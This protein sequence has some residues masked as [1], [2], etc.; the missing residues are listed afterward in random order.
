M[1]V[2]FSGVPRDSHN[3]C[4]FRIY[5]GKLTRC[6]DCGHAV[7][8]YDFDTYMD[9]AD[10]FVD[11]ANRFTPGIEVEDT[12]SDTATPIFDEWNREDILVLAEEGP[13]ADWEELRAI[14]RTGLENMA[15]T[16]NINEED[17]NELE[18]A[19]ENLFLN[20]SGDKIIFGRSNKKIIEYEKEM[21]L[22]QQ[23]K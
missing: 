10:D 7:K 6:P 17:A 23:T 13:F 1:T 8:G 19:K 21:A 4:F 5:I 15:K 9:D 14:V 18:R 20:L 22:M 3:M 16:E 12:S 11:W 2:F